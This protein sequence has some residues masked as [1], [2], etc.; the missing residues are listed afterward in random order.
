MFKRIAGGRRRG[1]SERPSRL[2][3]A[4]MVYQ[5][6]VHLIFDLANAKERVKEC[7]TIHSVFL[8]QTNLKIPSR[9][10]L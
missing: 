5:Y 4:G 8:P 1:H 10:I 7:E 9:G 6:T 2:F 3:E